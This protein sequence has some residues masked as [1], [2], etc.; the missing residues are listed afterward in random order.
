ML[1][2]CCIRWAIG[3]DKTWII[4]RP[5]DHLDH[6]SISR[7]SKAICWDFSTVIVEWPFMG[8]IGDDAA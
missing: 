7:I 4:A 1:I 6:I 2:I 8:S 5:D 3:I